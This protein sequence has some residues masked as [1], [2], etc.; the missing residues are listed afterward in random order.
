MKNIENIKNEIVKALLP[1]KQEK[2]ILFGSYANGNPTEDSDID[3]YVVTNDDFIPQSW[4]EKMKIVNRVSNYIN[5]IR[6][7]YSVDLIVH[8]KAMNKKFYKLNSSFSRII[9]ED[10]V[11][12][13]E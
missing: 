12:L 3:L 6:K 13:Y 10:G 2:I 1:L 5:D 9:R 7:K 8:T 4:G 11:Y